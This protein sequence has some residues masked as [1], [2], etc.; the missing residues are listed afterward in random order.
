MTLEDRLS[1]RGEDSKQKNKFGP[2][3]RC[4]VKTVRFIKRDV[5]NSV[6]SF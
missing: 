6:K 5:L 4:N 3:G 2:M 1:G